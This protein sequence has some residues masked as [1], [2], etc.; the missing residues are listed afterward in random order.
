VVVVVNIAFIWV[1]S[2]RREVL[3]GA[4]VASFRTSA[5]APVARNLEIV[6]L[7]E[8]PE[9]I[10]REAEAVLDDDPLR[11][12]YRAQALIRQNPL[13]VAAAQLMGRAGAAMAKS[14]EAGRGSVK[15]V[16]KFL[17]SGD[18]DAAEKMLLS[19]LRKNPD[20]ADLK[21]RSVRLGLNL[22]QIYALK[23]RWGDAEDQLKRGRAMFPLDKTWGARLL[24]LGRIKAMGAEERKAWVQFL[25]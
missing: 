14:P 22:A 8:S 20:D 4:A 23:E 15:E 24:F 1:R 2:H 11:A 5:Q 18:L 10:R 19:L 9:A 6:D 12:Y 21:A 3:L 17:A 13:D 16:E 7:A 25:G